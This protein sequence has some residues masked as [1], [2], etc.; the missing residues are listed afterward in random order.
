MHRLFEY[1][2]PQRCVN[3]SRIIHTKEMPLCI[4]CY[5]NL[6]FTHWELNDQNPTYQNLQEHVPIV[7]A[8]S[9]LAYRSGNAAKKL[10]MANKYYNQR[11]IGVFMAI[12]AYPILENHSFDLILSVPSHPRTIRQRGYNQV[13][14]MAEHLAKML[15]ID[16]DKDLLKRVKRRDSQTH[17]NRRERYSSL[18]QAF[19][20]K[21]LNSSQNKILLLDDV[22]TSGATL[23]SCCKAILAQ[24]KAKIS[25]LTMAKAM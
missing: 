22:L 8:T 9:I 14:L 7:S 18:V 23:S 25:V 3:C 5:E 15:S 4:S 1:I 2:F 12:L 16:F 11:Q 19:E 24:N 13:H 20:A 21:P 10:I 17:R 6:E